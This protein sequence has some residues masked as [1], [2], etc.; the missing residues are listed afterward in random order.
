MGFQ[1]DQTWVGLGLKYDGMAVLGAE[2]FEGVATRVDSAT[3]PWREVN[4][5]SIRVGLGLGGSVGLAAFVGFNMA[6]LEWGDGKAL[7]DWGLTFAIPEARVGL[8]DLKAGLAIQRFLDGTDFLRDTFIA[9]MRNAER[10]EQLRDFASWLWST[11][12]T[13]GEGQS[14]EP[15]IVVIDVP[16]VGGGAE[17]SAYLSGGEFSAGPVVAG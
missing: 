6:L 2:S 14:D 3:N 13:Y 9:E 7:S 16:G 1:P 5:T 12:E 4:V 10:I 15:T 8:D 11:G 17:V